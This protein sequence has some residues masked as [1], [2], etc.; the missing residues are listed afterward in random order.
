[1]DLI[2]LQPG[3]SDI[4]GGENSWANGGSLIDN[5]EDVWK[6]FKPPSK[7][8]GQC[9]ELVSVHQGMK[10]QITTDVSNSARTS[11]RPII[12]EFTCVK[13][14]DKTSV[15][16]FEY[17]LRAQPL[18]TDPS[19]PTKIY[20]ARNSG[21]KTAN[22]LTMSLRNALISEIQFQSHPDDMPT[23]QFKLSFTEILW[24]YT[25]QKADTT[26]AG[27]LSAGWSIARNR[28]IGQFT[29]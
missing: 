3:D 2:L 14:V 22:I 17:C 13:Y 1:M 19:K 10:Q 26:T 29:D 15:K 11:G 24:T 16:F 21:D 8:M 27:N 20:I 18:D 12:T 4:F 6:D 9:L 5:F 7:N 25:V 28:P 23:E